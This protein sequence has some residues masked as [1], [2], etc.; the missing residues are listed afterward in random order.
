MVNITPLTWASAPLPIKR[1]LLVDLGD[2]RAEAAD[3]PLD[4]GVG[5]D[6]GPLA[7]EVPGGGVPVLEVDEPEV[8]PVP[9]EQLDRP[10]VQRRRVGAADAGGLADEGRLGPLLQDDQGVVE[11][12]PA[13]AGQPTR[14][15][16]G[17]STLTPLG[18]Y[19]K[20]PPVQNAAWRLENESAVGETASGQEVAFEEL[21]MLS[22]A[23]VARS[24]RIAPPSLAGSADRVG[25]ALIC[26][27][28]VA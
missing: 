7:A 26:S 5:A 13:P 23:A 11:V 21:G 25:V 6:Q 8:G 22:F 19:S 12:D 3:G 15:N 28:P 18:T 4:R 17:T 1:D 2:P 27:R 10:G 16:R 9:D 14:L 24:I 20:V